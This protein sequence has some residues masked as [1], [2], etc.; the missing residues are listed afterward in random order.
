MTP[1]VTVSERLEPT[2]AGRV[3]TIASGV[4]R[5]DRASEPLL[6]LQRAASA[7]RCAVLVLL[8]GTASACGLPTTAI[9]SPPLES[10][11]VLS[12]TSLAFR[13]NPLNNFDDFLG[14]ELYYKVYP[15]RVTSG[16]GD[17][18]TPDALEADRAA[19][20][21]EPFAPNLS[22]IEARR[23]V[24]L[25]AASDRTSETAV[26]LPSA[27]TVE[28]HLG[29]SAVQ[30]DNAFDIRLDFPPD[31]GTTTEI[32]AEWPAGS[33]S[34]R[35]GFRRRNDDTAAVSQPQT[36]ESFWSAAG[37]SVDDFDVGEMYAGSEDV[38]V[39]ALRRDL[40]ARIAIV[41]V[42]Y[43]TDALTFTPIFSEPVWI[44]YVEINLTQ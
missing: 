17:A 6:Q 25:G 27:D 20:S 23:F 15:A 8:I 9:L 43:G 2:G 19:I 16:S 35:I 4:H 3:A 18:T 44:G 1:A 10:P 38:T 11:L 24:R 40:T 33:T 14:Y 26:A 21:A 39:T 12:S 5:V 37:Y 36:L 41:A 28:P 13:H 7:F 32:I 42:A 34:R 31:S 29:V 22:R 30:R